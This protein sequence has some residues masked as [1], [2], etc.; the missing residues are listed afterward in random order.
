MSERAIESRS[1]PD[2][3]A[4]LRDAV[5]RQ[6]AVQEGVKAEAAKLRAE[7]ERDEKGGRNE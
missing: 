7:R 5:A 6:K 3:V 1:T 2:P 4:V